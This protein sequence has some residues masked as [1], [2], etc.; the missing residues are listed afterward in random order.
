VIPDLDAEDH[1]LEAQ[2][3]DRE[4]RPRREPERLEAGG[5]PLAG[6]LAED[7]AEQRVLL[8]ERR[9]LRRRAGDERCECRLELGIELDR[10]RLEPADQ[11][12]RV[13]GH[14][15][16]QRRNRELAHVD[17]HRLRHELG[18]QVAGLGRPVAA[19]LLASDQ[20]DQGERGGTA[21]ALGFHRSLR[22][23]NP[24]RWP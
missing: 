21:R 1:R 2:A 14:A 23:A 15:G 11:V 8:A 5:V 7:R 3:V 4:R 6:E 22:I 20:R 9:E 24:I 17:L 16:E 18:R 10:H 12:R 13:G 19:L